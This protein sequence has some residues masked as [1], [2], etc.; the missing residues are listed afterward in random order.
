MNERAN[1]QT[2]DQTTNITGIDKVKISAL[3]TQRVIGQNMGERNKSKIW[4]WRF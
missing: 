2:D 4:T 3:L 1:E